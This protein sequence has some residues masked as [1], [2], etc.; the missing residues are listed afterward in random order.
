MRDPGWPP[1]RRLHPSKYQPLAAALTAREEAAARFTF[2][3]IEALLGTPLP[4]LARR[5]RRWWCNYPPHG[6]QIRVWLDAGW[7]VAAVY[8]EE[9]TVSFARQDRPITR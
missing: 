7:R 6:P 5:D 4:P 1:R 3:E 8:I 9:E 2:A